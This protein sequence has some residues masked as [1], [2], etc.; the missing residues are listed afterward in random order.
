MIGTFGDWRIT[1]LRATAALAFGVLTLLWPGLTLLVL[2]VTFGAFVLFDGVSELVDVAR[3]DPA[4]RAHRGWRIFDGV[5][6]VLAGLV[7]FLWPGITALALL[8]LIAAWAILTGGVRLW[9]AI[10]VRH[11][12]DY[13]WLFGLAGALSVV[14][15][16]M[17]LITPGAGALV[18][19]WLIGWYSL[20][21]A[22]ILFMH[23]WY[24]RG[25]QRGSRV[26]MGSVRRVAM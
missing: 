16:V 14:F 20:A 4:V 13:A 10:K 24:Q 5:L 17:L 6:G 18:I 8:V 26:D 23:G 12:L 7:T 25:I 3:N 1:M 19:T 15:G 21:L 11:E 22:V 9:A 2:V